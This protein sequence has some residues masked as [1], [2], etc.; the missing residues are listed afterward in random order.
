MVESKQYSY[1]SY[2][3]PHPPTPQP[4]KN[5]LMGKRKDKIPKTLKTAG[6]LASEAT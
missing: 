3:N 1:Y 2:P 4:P 5:R 6:L